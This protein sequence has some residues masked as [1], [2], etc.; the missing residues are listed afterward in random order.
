[1]GFVI[2]TYDYIGAALARERWITV[3][4]FEPRRSWWCR[5]LRWQARR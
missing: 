1:M 4:E 3:V 5:L 2:D